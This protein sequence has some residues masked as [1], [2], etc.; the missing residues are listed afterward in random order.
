MEVRLPIR[1]EYEGHGILSYHLDRW[2][3]FFDLVNGKLLEHVGF[4]Y[5]GHCDDSWRLRST[6]DRLIDLSQKKHAEFDVDE[7]LESFKLAVRGRRGPH[8]QPME[9]NNDWWALGQHFGL[10]TPLLDWSQNPYVAAY[11]AFD[12]EVSHTTRTIFG[13]DTSELPQFRSAGH[14]ALSKIEL[15]Q[16]LNRDHHK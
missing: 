5:R 2:D 16:P 11:F 9:S 10:S 12:A 6:L 8:P 3:A 13:L 4:V 14:P 7:Y 15:F 1:E